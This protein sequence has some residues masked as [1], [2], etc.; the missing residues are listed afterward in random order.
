MGKIII[1]NDMPDVSGENPKTSP[2]AKTDTDPKVKVHCHCIQ[3][4][5]SPASPLCVL[6]NAVL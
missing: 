4:V 3:G 5:R 6:V 1:I 2:I